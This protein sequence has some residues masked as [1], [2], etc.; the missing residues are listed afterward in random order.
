MQ[1]ASDILAIALKLMEEDLTTVTI[2]TW[3]EHSRALGFIDNTLV[4]T[5]D[6][7]FKKP[8]VMERY[9]EIL[10]KAL[11]NMFSAHIKVFVLTEDEGRAYV[12]N[13]SHNEE[14]LIKMTA[15]EEYTFDN[16]VIG[17]SNKF[18]HAAAV[19]VAKQQANNSYNPLF[20]YGG[21]GLGKTHLMKA[22]AN[23]VAKENP[24]FKIVY[25]KGDQF[26]NEMIE[27]I[28]SGKRDEF[29][30]RYRYADILLVDDIQFIAGKEQTQIEF[31]HTFNT[32][33]ES[34]KQIVLTSDRSPKE[35]YTLED[36]LKSRFESGILADISPPDY[37]TRMAIIGAKAQSL[38]I[39][40]P[41][42]LTQYI[43]NSLTAN[44]RQLEGVVKKINACKTLMHL[45]INFDTVKAAIQDIF[46]DNPGLNPSVSMV[47]EEVA[48]YY[49]IAPDLIRGTSRNKDAVMPRQLAMYISRD[50]TGR[51]F[52]DIGKEFGKDYSTVMHSVKKIEGLIKTDPMIKDIARDLSA[53]I[54]G[55]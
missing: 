41:P 20:I 52:P 3:F 31:F 54:R 34:N 11:E 27:A 16:F 6:E 24:H 22:I 43:S 17:A 36:R 23:H 8:I 32:L 26:T 30:S 42:E 9:V 55:N 19:A 40:I 38:D 45:E 49:G 4:I 37:E 10:E 28:Q 13:S 46:Y 44:V 48:R 33:H 15:P 1:S 5:V 12:I 25:I 14:M 29:R 7:D 50:I 53:N 35:I 2:M 47:I 18:A 51:S 39:E 21:S